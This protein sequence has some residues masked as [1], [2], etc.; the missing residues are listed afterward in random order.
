[1]TRTIGS[2]LL[3]VLLA[4]SAFA[5]SK[6]AKPADA[7]AM[8]P[9][10]AAQ[11]QK[12]MEAMQAHGALGP[13]HAELKKMVGTWDVAVKMWPDAGMPA[14]DFSG[15]AEMKMILGDHYLQ[16]D[17]T[18]TMMGQPFTGISITGFDNSLKQYEAIW[19]D[20]MGSSIMWA[21]GKASKDG[22]TINLKTEMTDPLKKKLIKGREVLRIESDTKHV[23]EMYG[24][25]LAGKEYKMMEITYT[26]K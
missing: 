1:M 10:K 3:V 15:K 25:S 2:A 17:F 14:Q 16:Q 13:E 18:A 19:I 22:K 7:P 12:M 6:D 11:M 8:D 21:E 5:Q 23:M 20:S 24:P 26:K 4:S 9:K